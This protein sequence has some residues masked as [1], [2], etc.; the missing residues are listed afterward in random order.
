[1]FQTLEDS[2]ERQFITPTPLPTHPP[3]RPGGNPNTLNPKP[4]QTVVNPKRGASGQASWRPRRPSDGPPGAGD[5]LDA[6]AVRTLPLRFYDNCLDRNTCQMNLTA[7]EHLYMTICFV[8]SYRRGHT[9]HLEKRL[10]FEPGF[11]LLGTSCSDRS[12]SHPKRILGVEFWPNAK[13]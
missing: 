13:C 9:N 10:S 7:D 11:D 4:Y 2:R 8:D 12:N 1:M 3:T 5:A 6:C